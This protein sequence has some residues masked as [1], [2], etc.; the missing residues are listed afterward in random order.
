M[1]TQQAKAG[2][3]LA[4]L[5]TALHGALAA[6]PQDELRSI[7]LV[8]LDQR[9]AESVRSVAALAP[10]LGIT[11][12]CKVVCTWPPLKCTVTCDIVFAQLTATQV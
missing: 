9:V 12:D 11:A 7:P 5:E 4:D 8:E 1:A 6:I 3:S 2:P 10:S